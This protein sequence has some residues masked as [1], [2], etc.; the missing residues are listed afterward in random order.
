M[1][2]SSVERCR[3]ESG[4][5]KQNGPRADI[6]EMASYLTV[7]EQD[8]LLAAQFAEHGEAYNGGVLRQ[9]GGSFDPHDEAV[10]TFQALA[11]LAW[12][13]SVI[14]GHPDA[15][16]AFDKVAQLLNELCNNVKMDLSGDGS[17]PVGA[18]G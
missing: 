18:A 2:K 14:G 12:A 4:I 11:E 3:L 5:L 7:G 10:Q 6:A 17:N 13:D 8:R 1:T 15:R 16:E 9:L